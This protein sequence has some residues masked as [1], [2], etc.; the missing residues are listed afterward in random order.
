VPA[1]FT[2]RFDRRQ[3]LPQTLEMTATAHFMHHRYSGFDAPR[4][5]FP[6]K[7]QR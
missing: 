2:V 6:P 5:I 1:W 3:L 4:R 7:Q